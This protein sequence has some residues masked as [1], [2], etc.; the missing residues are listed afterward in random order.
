[1]AEVPSASSTQYSV[2]Y[3]FDTMQAAGTMIRIEN[4]NGEEIL[5]FAPAK[6]YQSV[7]L[8]SPELGNGSY[9]LYSGGASSGSNMDGLY[10][11]GTYTAGTQVASFTL[12][13]VVTSAGTVGGFGGGPGGGGPGGMPG[14]GQPPQPM[15]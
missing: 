15:Q 13:S 10:S 2:L 14:G 1:M 11:D 9:V 4:E 7:V 12:S 8:S 5:T 6:S 3:G